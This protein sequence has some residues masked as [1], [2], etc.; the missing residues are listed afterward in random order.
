MK[1][2]LLAVFSL[3][4]W[5]FLLMPNAV[6]ADSELIRNFDIQIVAHKDGSFSVKETILYDFGEAVRHGIYRTIPTVSSVGK[7]YRENNITFTE[8]FRDGQNESFSVNTGNNQVSAKI[9]DPNQTITGAHTYIISYD[10][11]NGIGSNY[12]DHDEIYWN[13]TGNEW[14]IPILSASAAI[15]TDFGVLPNQVTC[16][17]GSGGSKEQNC[18]YAP[19]P[20]FNP[21]TTTAPLNPSQGFTVVAGFPV[22]TFPKSLL[23]KMPPADSSDKIVLFTRL[24]LGV[25]AGFNFILAPGLFIWYL[26]YKRK[27]RFGPVSV[28]FDLPKDLKGGRITP[29]EAG[30]IDNAKLDRDDVVAT[31]FDLAIRKYIKIEQIKNKKV[32]GIFGGGN[33]FNILKLKAYS[34]AGAFEKVLLERLFKDGNEVTI[35]SLKTDFYETFQDLEKEIFNSLVAKKYYTKNPK[36]Q[37]GLLFAAGLISLTFLGFLFSLILFFLAY[38]LN[39]RT[40]KGDEIDFKVDG[41]K[42]FL[43]NMSREYKWQAENLYIVE[44][45]IP[46]AMALGYIDDFMKQLKIIYPNYKPNWYSGNMAFYAISSSMVNSMNSGFTT[47]APSSSSGFSG[48]G[49]SGGGGGGGGGGS[50]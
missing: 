38:K 31:I 19:A 2:I 43:K 18:K 26:K 4:I 35:S 21:I 7:L 36:T 50:W 37:R 17:T 23:S 44:K 40:G 12:P 15:T 25:A 14:K 29:A 9:G 6:F 24:Y 16:F 32:L 46:Y 41:L 11:K 20:P 1:N 22:N 39:G 3:L 8:I 48:G 49:F 30:I 27:K 13:V 10:V 34:D 28:N 47:V 5:I 45:Y 42:L 33:D